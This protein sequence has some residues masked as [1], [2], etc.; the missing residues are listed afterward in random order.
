[1]ESYIKTTNKNLKNT[2]R[3]QKYKYQIRTADNYIMLKNFFQTHFDNQ[4]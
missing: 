4:S 3:L 1:M 2:R